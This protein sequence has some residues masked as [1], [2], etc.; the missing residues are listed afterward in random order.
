[1]GGVY[2]RGP[3]PFPSPSIARGKSF[4][5]L[6]FEAANSHKRL[7]QNGLEV[8]IFLDKELVAGLAVM[9]RFSVTSCEFPVWTAQSSEW[10]G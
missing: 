9:G 1:M 5:M 10:L 3:S 4:G 8:K 2:G 6:G 7:N